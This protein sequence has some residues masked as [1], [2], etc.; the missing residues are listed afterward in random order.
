M[1][2]FRRLILSYKIPLTL[3]HCICRVQI[4]I[5]LYRKICEFI[6]NVK[7]SPNI[8]P[9]M[10]YPLPWVFIL[11]TLGVKYFV[12]ISRYSIFSLGSL[13]WLVIQLLLSVLK[14]NIPCWQNCSNIYTLPIWKLFQIF[15]FIFTYTIL[16]DTLLKN[17][18]L[19]NYETSNSFQFFPFNENRISYRFTEIIL[20]LTSWNVRFRPYMNVHYQEVNN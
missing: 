9:D 16:I 1:P 18:V 6:E 12:H 19:K 4:S 10:G 13:I 14:V 7:Q 20:A 2:P 11:L 5:L 8:N 15:I 17:N 3:W